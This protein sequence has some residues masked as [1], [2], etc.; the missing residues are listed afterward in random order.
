MSRH[1]QHTAGASPGRG[2]PAVFFDRVHSGATGE[3]T[4]AGAGPTGGDRPFD[5]ADVEGL[6]QRRKQIMAGRVKT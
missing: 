5:P 1:H 3:R 2:T 4:E 6:L